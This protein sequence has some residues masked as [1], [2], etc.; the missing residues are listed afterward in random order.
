MWRRLLS[1]ALPTRSRVSRRSRLV[2]RTG[3]SSSLAAA[4]V[5][6][7]RQ[8]LSGNVTVNVTSAG[9]L[10]VLGDAEDNRLRIIVNDDNSFTFSSDDDTTVN[11][12]PADEAPPIG[13]AGPGGDPLLPPFQAP[14]GVL[15]SLAQGDDQIEIVGGQLP[16]DELTNLPGD[17]TLVLGIGDDTASVRNLDVGD[18]IFVGGGPDDGVDFVQVRNVE[19]ATLRVVTRGGADDVRV[20]Q[21]DI[22][23]ILIGSG[24]DD[25][26][27]VLQGAVSSNEIFASLG[28]GTDT[29]YDARNDASIEDFDLKVFGREGADRIVT[30][31]ADP[32]TTSYASDLRGLETFRFAVESNAGGEAA[33][34]PVEVRQ[35][36]AQAYVGGSETTTTRRNRLPDVAPADTSVVPVFLREGETAAEAE[37]DFTET[38]SGLRYR[39]IDAGNATRP[40]TADDV[41]VRYRLYLADN[42]LREEGG[43]VFALSD[44]IE[45]WQEGIPLIGEGG[46]I[47]LIAPPN[48][49]YGSIPGSELVNE[50]LYFEV[51]LLA[52][53][54]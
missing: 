23:T 37:A 54:P 13:F 34:T 22:D 44:L 29:I 41:D 3:A 20:E 28:E 16:Q 30:L 19:A 32:N 48:I 33:P 50:T 21:S 17:I 31:S 46:T 8:L 53:N 42:S 39:V 18:S 2:R 38:A 25:D 5:C 9:L 51:D 14:I 6:E 10:E 45:A 40:T 36:L 7:P 52:V 12:R 1:F 4:E 11:N 15:V 26:T 49:A 35:T 47:Q 43:R 27:V 24:T